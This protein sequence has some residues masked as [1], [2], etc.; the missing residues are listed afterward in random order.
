MKTPGLLPRRPAYSM[1]FDGALWETQLKRPS[2]FSEQHQV[3]DP[4]SQMMTKQPDEEPPPWITIKS[5]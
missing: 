2:F 1:C 3:E 5:E 4:S